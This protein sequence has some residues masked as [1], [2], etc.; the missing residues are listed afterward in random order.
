KHP[1]RKIPRPAS[2]PLET[3]TKIAAQNPDGYFLSYTCYRG[4]LYLQPST[5]TIS[6]CILT[7]LLSL[8]PCLGT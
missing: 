6:E 5:P 2:R 8:R 7:A 4:R 1:D 3:L